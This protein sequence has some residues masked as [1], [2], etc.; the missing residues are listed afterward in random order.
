L[1]RN[2]EA[3]VDP[4]GRDARG[5][6]RAVSDAATRLLTEGDAAGTSVHYAIPPTWEWTFQTK[7]YVELGFM[8]GSCFGSPEL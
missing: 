7:V 4:D 1:R 2:T 5:R 6:S 3:E 8:V